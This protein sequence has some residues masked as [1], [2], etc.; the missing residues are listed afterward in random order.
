MHTYAPFSYPCGRQH[1][2]EWR[3]SNPRKL[4]RDSQRGGRRWL[5]TQISLMGIAAVFMGIDP[6]SI[7]TSLSGT[8]RALNPWLP[9]HT[10]PD[11][12]WLV[13]NLYMRGLTSG[14]E[15]REGWCRLYVADGRT[16]GQVID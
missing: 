16:G 7:T 2:S 15:E 13:T 12:K 9:A 6:S 1:I 4:C 11:A 14:S 5:L 3:K 10:D 8:L